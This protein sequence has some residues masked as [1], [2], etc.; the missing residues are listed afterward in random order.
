MQDNFCA[1][2]GERKLVSQFGGEIK[3]S[4]WWWKLL[5]R[6]LLRL[7]HPPQAH[8]T[9]RRSQ[10]WTENGQETF[11]TSKG[12]L[13]SGKCEGSVATSWLRFSIF[14]SFRLGVRIRE[15]ARGTDKM[16]AECRE[17]EK[18]QLTCLVWKQ[19]SKGL[20]LNVS[21]DLKGKLLR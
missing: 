17:E 16:S 15:G 8:N 18:P 7:P 21:L 11:G 2:S 10:G 9:C 13:E 6:D 4:F 12:N 1:G 5:P 20:V 19:N 3:R 14:S